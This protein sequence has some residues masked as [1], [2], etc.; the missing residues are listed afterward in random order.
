MLTIEAETGNQVKKS[1][2]TLAE[3]EAFVQ[4]MIN[5]GDYSLNSFIV[6]KGVKVTSS[7][8]LEDET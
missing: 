4:E 1:F 7:I 2:P 6:I 3:A 5:S 8:T